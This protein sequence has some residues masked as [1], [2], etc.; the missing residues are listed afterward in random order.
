M[1]LKASWLQMF[2]KCRVTHFPQQDIFITHKIKEKKKIIIL[3]QPQ[4]KT[5]HKLDHQ[6]SSPTACKNVAA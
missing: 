2:I 5:R 4:N 1:E 6:I 3:L